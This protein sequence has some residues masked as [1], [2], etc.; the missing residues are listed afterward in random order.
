MRT[1]IAALFL[2]TT[3]MGCATTPEPAAPLP[4]DA[5]VAAEVAEPPATATVVGTYDFV[6]YAQGDP[7]RGVLLINQASDGRYRA[8]VST[9]VTGTLVPT[10]VQV[11]GNRLTLR[12][13]DFSFL[14]EHTCD[15]I[16]GSWSYRGLTGTLIARR[17]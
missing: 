8:S 4:Q 1:S 15:E 17:R 6:L 5:D 13:P 7:V 10:Q 16:T 3:A 12:G 11:D 14:G 9:D 2:A